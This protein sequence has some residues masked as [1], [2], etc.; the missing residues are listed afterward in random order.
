MHG[1]PHHGGSQTPASESEMD[2]PCGLS[3]TGLSPAS[4]CRR[5][6]SAFQLGDDARIFRV[7]VE[8]VHFARVVAHVEEL[9]IGRGVGRIGALHTEGLAVIVDELPAVVANAIVCR[10]VMVAGV[11]HPVAV[12]HGFA[13]IARRVAFEVGAETA[14]LHFGGGADACVVE[15]HRREIDVQHHVAVDGVGA[16]DAGVAHDEGHP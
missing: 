15:E 9:P 12:I 1:I 16:D 7:V 13:P 14:A 4:F 2:W 3:Y 5:S 8:I 6:S 11:V 10:H